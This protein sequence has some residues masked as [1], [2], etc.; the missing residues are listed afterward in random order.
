MDPN[1]SGSIDPV[2]V[3]LALPVG[4]AAK[5]SSLDKPVSLGREIF[6]PRMNANQKIS[7]L[8]LCLKVERCLAT[9]MED[10]CEGDSVGNP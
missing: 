3:A 4:S 6:V 10:R 2:N 7:N 8:S 5:R 9:A 1:T